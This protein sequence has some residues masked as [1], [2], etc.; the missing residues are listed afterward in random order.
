[1]EGLE[2]FNSLLVLIP[3]RLSTSRRFEYAIPMTSENFNIA[4]SLHLTNPELIAHEFYFYYNFKSQNNMNE[5]KTTRVR[6]GSA[7]NDLEISQGMTS[8]KTRKYFSNYYYV[9]NSQN[10]FSTSIVIIPV[11]RIYFSNFEFDLKIVRRTLE[12][13]SKKYKPIN[14]DIRTG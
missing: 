8:M 10:S 12:I 4:K 13:E 2:E 6:E 1:M 14:Y 7:Q 9:G 3:E 5:R 11:N